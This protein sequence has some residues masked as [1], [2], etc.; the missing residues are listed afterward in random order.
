MVPPRGGI[1]ERIGDWQ[2]AL[3]ALK[4]EPLAACSHFP[5]VAEQWEAWW[6]R[7]NRKPLVMAQ[8]MRSATIR[9]DKA[10][11]LIAA[12][13]AWLGVR[14]RQLAETV[15]FGEAL[16]FIRVDIGPVATA[17]FLGAPLHLAQEENTSWQ[18]PIIDSWEN[19]PDLVFDPQQ[20]VCRTVAKLVQYV[21]ADARG[22]YLVGLPDLTGAMDVL[23]NLRTPEKLCLDLFE[24]RAA[25]MAAADRVV[26]VW[27]CCFSQLYDQILAAGAIPVQWI[28]C[29][30]DGP[31]TVP[32][33]DFNALIGPRDF[34]E[35][36]MPSLKAQA[37][38]AGRCCFH[39][40][41]P[42][43][44]RH[45]EILARDEDITA[46]QYTPGA[47]TP[48]ALAKLPL[49]QMLQEAQVPLFI[50]CPAV[51]VKE[52]ATALDPRGVAIRAHGVESPAQGTDLVAW[53]DAQFG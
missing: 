37:R 49:F 6:Q 52:L 24:Y 27:E 45:A 20:P 23:S 26:D 19:P 29:W 28:S 18:D 53:R 12:P 14:R 33:C 47:G 32:T 9:L 3:A 8:V 22:N 40:D 44:A 46:I 48:S 25:V 2:T 5:A 30:S 17:A 1:T 13:E 16:P 11:D 4:Q 51:E 7:E 43:A 34:Q 10:F 42:D 41:G 31:Y 35:V 15:F 36:C 50:E 21:A 38:R 39:L